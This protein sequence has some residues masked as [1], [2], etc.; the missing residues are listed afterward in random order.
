MSEPTSSSVAGDDAQDAR[1]ALTP[2]AIEGVLQDFR[3]WLQE[4]MQYPQ[5][6]VAEEREFHWQTLVAEFT[7]LRQEVN[8]QTRAARAQTEQN[9]EALKQLDQALA[10]LETARRQDEGQ[11][12]ESLRPLLKTLVDVYD[13]LALARREVA[14]VEAAVDTALMDAESTPQTVEE[15]VRTDAA[16]LSP[17]RHRPWWR[18]W[19]GPG[20][21]SD[22]TIQAL[23]TRIAALESRVDRQLET[24]AQV[25][26]LLRSILAGYTMGLARIDRALAQHDLEVIDCLGEPFDPEC[27]EV[28][29]VVAE[30]GRSGTEVLEEV[31]RGYLWRGRL[32]R[33]AQ[34]RV[35]RP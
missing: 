14:R 13:A 6:V 3:A 16:H 17:A 5:P 24:A 22:A 21:A 19:S 4:A 12:D 28:V 10:A 23:R 27:M 20:S 32:F 9:A 8:L 30:P 11:A 34:V 33:H 29:E 1:P 15:P 2:E 7:A 26:Q 18:R 31:R 35:A 25:R